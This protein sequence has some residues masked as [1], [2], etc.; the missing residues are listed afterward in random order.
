MEKE[1]GNFFSFGKQLLK[2]KKIIPMKM[3]P[4]ESIWTVG[5]RHQYLYWI[6]MPPK[7][8]AN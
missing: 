5:G 7:N 4:F 1:E 2:L 8:M 3:N 6:M